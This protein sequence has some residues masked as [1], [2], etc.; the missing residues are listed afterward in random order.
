MKAIKA[1]MVADAMAVMGVVAMAAEVTTMT[2]ETVMEA[3]AASER[4]LHI[5]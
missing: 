5:P 2:S 4:S 3:R 1:S